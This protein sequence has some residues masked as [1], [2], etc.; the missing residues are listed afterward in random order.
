MPATVR[1]RRSIP[2]PYYT[3]E[4]LLAMY[5]RDVSTGGYTPEQILAK[6]GTRPWFLKHPTAA[7][8]Y[9]AFKIAAED[10]KG[11]GYNFPSTNN[12]EVHVRLPKA[13]PRRTEN[14][15]AELPTVDEVVDLADGVGQFKVL[16]VDTGGRVHPNTA[17]LRVLWFF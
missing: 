10:T 5:T 12:D 4:Q 9:S 2:P 3:G 13:R 15:A 14:R 17:I 6:Y 8:P 7:P 11:R 16:S 1:A